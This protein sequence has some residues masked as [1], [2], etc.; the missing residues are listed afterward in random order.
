MLIGQPALKGVKVVTYLYT[1]NVY[2]LK[3]QDIIVADGQVTLS[4]HKH[5]LYFIW[6]TNNCLGS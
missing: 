5:Y 4:L 6:V 3:L 2:L 1:D